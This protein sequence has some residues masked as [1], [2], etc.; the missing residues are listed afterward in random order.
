MTSS[1]VL[2]QAKAAESAARMAADG[3]ARPDEILPLDAVE[4]YKVF[5]RIARA[6]GAAK[7][8]LATRVDAS[9]E[10][11]RRGYRSTADLLAHL[12]GGSI[13]AAKSELETSQSLHGLTSTKRA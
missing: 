3:V 5:D 9:G 8:L 1:S 11:A 6:A 2:E 10:A 12:A 13:G 4:L 7:L